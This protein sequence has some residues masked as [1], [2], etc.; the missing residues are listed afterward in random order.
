M[1]NLENSIVHYADEQANQDAKNE[2]HDEA[3]INLIE[4]EN[5]F[6]FVHSTL[7]D[8]ADPFSG[9]TMTEYLNS[10]FFENWN[11]IKNQIKDLENE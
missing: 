4:T 5:D 3:L 7:K 10:E 8:T 2:D 6:D 1:K 11:D 9:F